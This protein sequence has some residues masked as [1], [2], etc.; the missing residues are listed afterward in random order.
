MFYFMFIL[1]KTL[2][3]NGMKPFELIEH[4]E[5]LG[6]I[7]NPVSSIQLY[8]AYIALNYATSLSGDIAEKYY[9]ESSI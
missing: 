2:L 1:F 4:P 3:L 8:L 6:P 7:Q 9:P 5:L